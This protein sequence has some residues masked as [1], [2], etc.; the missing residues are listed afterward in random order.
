VKHNVV[1]EKRRP[2]HIR[3]FFENGYLVVENDYQKKRSIARVGV[4][5]I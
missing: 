2:L 5:K 3:I 4:Y 1:S